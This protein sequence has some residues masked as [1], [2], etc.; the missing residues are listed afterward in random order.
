MV[1]IVYKSIVFVV[2]LLGE[3]VH[4]READIVFELNVMHLE[5]SNELYSVLTHLYN[6]SVLTVFSVCNL[7]L[8]AQVKFYQRKRTTN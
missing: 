6:F 2:S 7:S 8:L 3:W 1:D 4:H 5:E